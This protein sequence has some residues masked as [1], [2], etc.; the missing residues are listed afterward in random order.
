MLKSELIRRNRVGASVYAGL[1]FFF[2]LTA[3]SAAQDYPNRPITIV[4]N[5][6]AGGAHHLLNQTFAD[7]AK[8]YL[9]KPQPILLTFKPGGAH[10]IGADYVLKQPADGYT[11]DSFAVDAVVK[12]AKDGPNANFSKDDFIPIGA[13]A[14]APLVLP[15]N[16]ESSFKTLEDFIDYAKK[17]PGKLSYGSTGIGGVIHLVGELFQSRCGIKLKH[18]PY[19]GAAPA[20]TALLGNHIDTYLGTPTAVLATNLKP[21]GGLRLLAVFDRERLIEF[22]E[23]PTCLER[24]YDVELSSWI[25]HV[26]RK[27]TPPQVVDIL[28]EIFKKTTEDPEVKKAISGIGYKPLSLSPQDTKKLIDGTYESAREMFTKL[29]LT[30]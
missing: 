8:K 22:P 18:I 25:S 23:A 14:M 1:L 16:K 20:L 29:G 21:G 30:K 11:V 27:G 26:V 17:N 12:L 7:N 6:D 28:R 10:T 24:G 3:P 19:S 13:L 9:P 5:T 4:V 15:V 2:I